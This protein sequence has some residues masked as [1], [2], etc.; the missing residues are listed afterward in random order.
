MSNLIVILGGSGTGKST[1][2]RNLNPDETFVINVLGKPLP[3]RGYRKLYNEEKKN[4]LESDN[5]SLLL[6]YLNG[7]NER[8]PEI[9]TVI[10][11]DF[12]FLMNNE[13]MRRC[14]EKSFDKFTEMGANIFAI[15][16]ACK[17]FRDDLSIYILCHPE[18]SKT[19]VVK[20]KTVGKMTDDYV[21]I[22]ER[23]TTLFHTQVIDGQYK[24]LTQHDGNLLAKTPMGMF[25]EMYIDNDLA[26][27]QKVINEY[28]N[29]EKNDVLA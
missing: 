13:F 11:D 18:L 12:I 17:A 26:E 7:I 28:Y 14:R 9:K 8:R 27:I 2:F 23:V 10:I 4:Y 1:S 5:H 16:E 6:K 29:G 22:S 3:F 25:D 15:M 19:G 21:C 20:P 24:F